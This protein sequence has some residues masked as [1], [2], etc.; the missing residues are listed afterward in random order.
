M[1]NH[2]FAFTL[3]GIFLAATVNKR[4]SIS[5]S[6]ATIDPTIQT[7]FVGPFAN[8][9]DN[10]LPNLD[11]TL[12]EDLRNKIRLNSRLR[13]DEN[14]PDI[15]FKGTLV[16]FRITAEAPSA[17]NRVAINRLTIVLAI[18]YIV[19]KE[20]TEGWTRNFSFFFDYPASTDFASVEEDAVTTI[21]EQLMEDIFNAAFSNW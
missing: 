12:A 14:N 8:N 18:E 15:E 19:N 3:I 10:A 7:Y 5:Q 4:C 16:D 20:D 21:S 6:G 17:D 11:Q 9:A 2:Y 1:R 13:R